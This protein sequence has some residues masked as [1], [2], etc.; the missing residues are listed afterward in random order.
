MPG[1]G[2]FKAPAENTLKM[3]PRRFT[4]YPGQKNPTIQTVATRLSEFD[5]YLIADNPRVFNLFASS[6][7][8]E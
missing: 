8:D 4:F 1:S 6:W 5:G 2:V 7:M 3:L